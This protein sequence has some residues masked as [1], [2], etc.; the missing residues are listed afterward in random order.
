L[1]VG[2]EETPLCVDLDGTLIRGDSTWISLF[3]MARRKPW[4]LPGVPLHLLRGRALAKDFLAS[5]VVPRPDQLTWR[6]SVI[7]FLRQEHDRGRRLLLTTGAHERVATM[8]ARHLG[9]FD[10]VI[11]TDR[12]TNRKGVFKLA[13]IHKL[14]GDQAFDFVSD[15]KADL[16]VLAAAR[17]V[18]LVAPPPALLEAA[19]RVSTVVRVFDAD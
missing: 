15:D 9:L 19:Q 13:A 8:V 1:T 16:P 5:H 17:L 14:L 12:G 10:D 2:P 7:A 4:L 11:A 6:E 3:L 18:Y